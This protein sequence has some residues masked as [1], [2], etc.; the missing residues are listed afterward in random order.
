MPGDPRG[1]SEFTLNLSEDPVE[2]WR[3]AALHPTDPAA[4]MRNSLRWAIPFPS[5]DIDDPNTLSDDLLDPAS[6]VMNK[7]ASN[8]AN[9]GDRLVVGSRNEAQQILAS[10]SAAASFFAGIAYGIKDSL[11][12]PVASAVDLG[13]VAVG[14]VSGGRYEPTWISATG[15]NYGPNSSYNDVVA[16]A[17]LS[18]NPVTGVGLAA[19]DL[20]GNIKNRNWE[21]TG[22][23]LGQLIGGFAIGGM[24]PRTNLSKSQ[25]SRTEVPPKKP[26][27]G[28]SSAGEVNSPLFVNRF[29][30]DAID[31]PRIVPNNALP[32]ISG[33][34]NYV[35]LEDGMLVVGKSPHTSLT[36]NAPVKVAGEIQLFNGDVK[37]VDNASGHYQPTGAGIKN[38]AEAAFN[39]IG[40]DASGKFRNKVWVPDSSLP[41]GGKWVTM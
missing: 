22:E 33:N 15:R 10:P 32:R 23:Q 38:I 2:R 41:R 37:W 16:R 34:F 39:D 36:N 7:L 3:A 19:Y 21:Q 18:S 12:Q 5:E 27:G 26:D 8:P 11:W 35:V 30:G 29:P 4:L 9:S 20:T 14:L 17:L 1:E 31:N 25:R 6:A 40:I 28:T 24:A 13:Q